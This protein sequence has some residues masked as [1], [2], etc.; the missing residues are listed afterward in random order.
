MAGKVRWFIE[1]D[2]IQGSSRTWPL[3]MQPVSWSSFS[4]MMQPASWS[5]FQQGL[6]SARASNCPGDFRRCG[7]AAGPA[8]VVAHGEN[9]GD[10]Q[11]QEC[12]F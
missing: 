3:M 6:D 10:R 12:V 1:L 7:A 8:A 11:V 2:V 4:K 5:F 9:R